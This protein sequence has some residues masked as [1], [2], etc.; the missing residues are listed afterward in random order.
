MLLVMLT[1]NQV[2]IVI[3]CIQLTDAS[4]VLLFHTEQVFSNVLSLK[5]PSHIHNL[6]VCNSFLLCVMAGTTQAS[7]HLQYTTN[8]KQ[9]IILKY[10]VVV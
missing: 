1:V 7:I 4:F 2:H 5:T 10:N 8:I 6:F 3:I 9:Y